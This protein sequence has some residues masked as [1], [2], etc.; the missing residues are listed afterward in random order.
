MDFREKIFKQ[1]S[2]MIMHYKLTYSKL[3]IFLYKILFCFCVFKLK[4][5]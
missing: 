4:L 3:Y 5:K 2:E 1:F